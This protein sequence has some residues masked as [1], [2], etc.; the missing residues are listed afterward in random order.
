LIVAACIVITFTLLCS[1]AWLLAR[2]R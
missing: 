1:K 2:F